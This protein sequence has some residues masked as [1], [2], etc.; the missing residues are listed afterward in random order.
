[1]EAHKKKGR[2]NSTFVNRTVKFAAAAAI[3]TG[4]ARGPEVAQAGYPLNEIVAVNKNITHEETITNVK[5]PSY[6]IPKYLYQV[7]SEW[8]KSHEKAFK[9]WY[10]LKNI[11]QK[12]IQQY[13]HP[14]IS[15][16]QYYKLAVANYKAAD[17]HPSSELARMKQFAILCTN[18][19]RISNGE[20]PIVAVNEPSAQQH[21]NSMLLKNYVSHWNTENMLP[22]MR[23]SIFGGNEGAIENVD[24][25]GYKGHDPAY[26]L[27]HGLWAM[28]F[29]DGAAGNGHRLTILNPTN[30]GL[31]VGIA[32]GAPPNYATRLD[33]EFI[34]DY[35]H[36]KQSPILSGGVISLSGSIT[37]P[38]HILQK[39]ALGGIAI[40]YNK[41]L[42]YISP[43]RLVSEQYSGHKISYGFD[44][45]LVALSD[46]AHVDYRNN[47]QQPDFIK[48][49]FK[50]DGNF[51][52]SINVKNLIEKNG[53]GEYTLLIWLK[54]NI[55]AP[56]IK[57]QYENTLGQGT[58]VVMKTFFI[59]RNGNQYNPEL[60]VAM[61]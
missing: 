25:D 17:W 6:L 40:I 39:N 2:D 55:K 14:S 53:A 27:A 31:S 9:T 3:L 54:P 46:T 41:P 12:T 45:A 48:K 18:M 21:A 56:A 35:I 36:W 16:D 52:I 33:E 59:D 43:K 10:H 4:L 61:R 19:D 23:Y 29:S 44:D 47:P 28:M 8:I 30:T 42:H 49:E 57:G 1:M 38:N 24:G 11:N 20:R 51:N 5:V 15:F 7:P 34:C 22:Y 26:A 58:R 13:V 32:I 50:N 37:D 60:T